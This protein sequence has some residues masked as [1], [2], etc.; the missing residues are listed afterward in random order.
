MTTEDPSAA[1]PGIDPRY[2]FCA[3]RYHDFRQEGD[4]MHDKAD[5]WFDSMAATSGLVS[6]GQ[7]CGNYPAEQPGSATNPET[8][9]VPSDLEADS[10][11]ELEKG[12]DEETTEITSLKRV[13][14]ADRGK[15]SPSG[16]DQPCASNQTKDKALNIRSTPF[17]SCR[18]G[19]G[20]SKGSKPRTKGLDGE[21]APTVKSTQVRRS[22]L[23]SRTVE[24]SKKTVKRRS[25]VAAAV[26]EL[27]AAKDAAKVESRPMPTRSARQVT[28]GGKENR[29]ELDANTASKTPSCTKLTVPRSP[30]LKTSAIRTSNL[31]TTEDRQIAEAKKAASEAEA[32]RRRSQVHVKRVL[33]T[34]SALPAPSS[35]PL[36]L[37]E[38]FEFATSQRKHVM[39]TRSMEAEDVLK[40]SSPHVPLAEQTMKYLTRTP[41]R[42]RTVPKGQGPVLCTDTTDG[43][44]ELTI[45]KSPKLSTVSRKREQSC[46]SRAQVEEEEMANMPKFSALPL[47]EKVMKS[48][49]DLG[50]PRVLPKPNTVAEPFT[51]GTDERATAHQESQEKLTAELHREETFRP[52]TRALNKRILRGATFQPKKVARPGE[53]AVSPQLA[54]RARSAARAGPSEVFKAKKVA[55]PGEQAVS[56]Q[57]A[58]RARS[59]ARAGPSEGEKEANSFVF[60]A[61]PL[62]AFNK[63]KV[64]TRSKTG[65]T[66]PE[67]FDLATDVRGSTKAQR[68]SALLSEQEEEDQR[69]SNSFVAR[70]L[71][72]TALPSYKPKQQRTEHQPTVAAPFNLAST[73][74]HQACE[75]QREI[76]M[77]EQQDSEV[78]LHRG[79]RARPL[80]ESHKNPMEVQKASKPLTSVANIQLASDNRAT[81]RAEFDKQLELKVKSAKES[82]EEEERRQSELES[83]EVKLLRQS[84]VHKA[85]KKPNFDNPFQA[86]KGLISATQAQ[87]PQFSTKTRSTL[88]TSMR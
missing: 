82:Q 32:K 57:L 68:F 84:L 65:G 38:E 28:R 41:E 51:L 11:S 64:A 81:Q 16:A 15:Q 61:R 79:T 62:P 29:D 78:K 3:P 88:K 56:P 35:K 43:A 48:C 60:K 26:A 59:A 63:P 42:Y 13:D 66:E 22:L 71:P 21:E 85:T 34:T 6:P 30:K 5:E 33:S 86:K 20:S 76:E 40:S 45:P 1:S 7:S 4:G 74:R 36:T 44:K 47:D 50:V 52:K 67:P 58:T 75:E 31:P 17:T 18:V 54:T 53:Q 24:K 10:V 27:A 72:A 9:A 14:S 25:L 77:R 87:S 12:V 2:E 69:R 55:R 8:S 83:K 80:P 73:L 19:P 37:P 23:A 39:T 70:Q 49:G 46:K